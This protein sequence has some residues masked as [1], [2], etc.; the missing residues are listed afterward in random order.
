MSVR[1]I[2]G[3]MP[4]ATLSR[5]FGAYEKTESRIECGMTRQWTD[6]Q[7]GTPDST[8]GNGP[9]AEIASSLWDSQ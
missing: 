6:C 2:P 4:Q 3:A 5:P 9:Y 7:V 1:L 8:K